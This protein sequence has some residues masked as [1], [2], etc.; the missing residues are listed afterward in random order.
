MKKIN[1]AIYNEFFHEQNEESIRKIYPDGI[2]GAIAAAIKDEP[3]V[4]NIITATLDN[5]TNVLTQECLDNTDVLFFTLII[6]CCISSIVLAII[7]S[8]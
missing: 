1:V 8:Q 6:C 5:H 3:D 2:H 7:N 4:G